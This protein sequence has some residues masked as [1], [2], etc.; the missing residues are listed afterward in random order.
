VLGRGV[1]G[2]PVSWEAL[3]PGIIDAAADLL[4]HALD[5]KAAAAK[6]AERAAI[7]A[8]RLAADRKAAIKFGKPKP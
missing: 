1:G 6:L 3:L 2:S 4:I 7:R 8:A 5:E